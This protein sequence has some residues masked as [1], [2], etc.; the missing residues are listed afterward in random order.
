M[1]YGGSSEQRSWRRKSC[2]MWHRVVRPFVPDIRRSVKSFVFMLNCTTHQN[3]LI[4]LSC[5]RNSC[6]APFLSSTGHNPSDTSHSVCWCMTLL[7]HVVTDYFD[8]PAVA[9]NRSIMP[10]IWECTQSWS[11]L[12]DSESRVERWNWL[13]RATSVCVPLSCS[14]CTWTCT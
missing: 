12:S 8:V 3:T 2:A 9:I 10:L 7:T 14:C 5:F 1:R 13:A 4:F 11:E 6:A